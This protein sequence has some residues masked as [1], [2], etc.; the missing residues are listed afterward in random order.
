MLDGIAAE[1]LHTRDDRADLGVA[2]GAGQ[3]ICEQGGDQRLALDQGHLAAQACQHE[4]VLAQP[5]RG[6]EHLRAYALGDTHGLGDHLPATATE[7]PPV[8]RRAFDEIHPHR[9]WRLRA[10]LLDLQA[11]GADLHGKA[12]VVIAQRQL[13]ALRPLGS[14]GLII[15][16]Q[17]LDPDAAVRQLLHHQILYSKKLNDRRPRPIYEVFAILPDQNALR[18]P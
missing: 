18:L 12:C 10:Q 6:V 5:R 9:P 17:C 4:G 7:H 16:R 14:Q 1:Q 8:G 3:A 15:G 11:I 13:Q 2:A